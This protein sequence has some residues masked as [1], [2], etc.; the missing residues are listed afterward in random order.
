MV[1]KACMMILCAMFIT[2]TLF[3]TITDVFGVGCQCT[4]PP[5]DPVALEEGRCWQSNRTGYTVNVL[6]PFPELLGADR[7]YK[8][9]VTKGEDCG[10]IMW[11]FEI[12]ID[13]CTGFC[14]SGLAKPGD[15]IVELPGYPESWNWEVLY[16]GDLLTGYLKGDTNHCI[17]KVSLNP[18]K[19]FPTAGITV[20][21]TLKAPDGGVGRSVFSSFIKNILLGDYGRMWVPGCETSRLTLTKVPFNIPREGG[22]EPINCWYQLDPTGKMIDEMKCDGVGVEWYPVSQFVYCVPYD[23]GGGDINTFSIDGATYY[24][25]RGVDAND[26]SGLFGNPGTCPRFIKPPG[27]WLDPCKTY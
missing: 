24:C 4:A 8:Y 2:I 20:K 5:C 6:T 15:I 25:H 21:L 18:L 11:Y 3:S 22:G 19:P 10:R 23:I 7:I 1:K 27:V 26:G 13:T 14:G 12:P 16:Q 9:N 17:V